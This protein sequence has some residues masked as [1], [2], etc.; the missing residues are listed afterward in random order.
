MT[1]Y[2]TIVAMLTRAKIKFTILE[3]T[4]SEINNQVETGKTEI[5][6]EDGYVGFVSVFYFDKTGALRR[7]AAWE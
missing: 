1:D 7:V 3:N 5:T 4:Q 2:E 6:V